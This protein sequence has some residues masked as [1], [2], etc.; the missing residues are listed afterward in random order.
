MQW[1]LKHLGKVVVAIVI[2]FVT[3]LITRWV[4]DDS[5][6]LVVRQYF[7]TVEA[8]APVPTSVGDLVIAYEQPTQ[9]FES[10]YVVEVVNNGRGPENDLRIKIDFPMPLAYLKEPD[11]RLYRP[12][13]IELS[14]KVFFMILKS[15]P[16]D[17]RISITFKAPEDEQRLC[18]VKIQLAGAERQGQVEPLRGV[19]CD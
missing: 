18:E 15:F 1:F 13:K 10:H 7:N 19:S 9:A 6:E 8:E 5:S 12:E 14:E 11:L 2:V 4:D 16:R 3:A 17:A